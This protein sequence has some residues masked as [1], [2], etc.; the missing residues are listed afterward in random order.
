MHDIPP[1]DCAMNPPQAWAERDALAFYFYQRDGHGQDSIADCQSHT[2]HYNASYFAQADALLASGIISRKPS[3]EEVLKQF[4][5][6][7]YASKGARVEGLARA[8]LGAKG[9][10]T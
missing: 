5:H 7:G 4:R 9:E 3:E 10:K 8:V 6:Y 2:Q 1:K